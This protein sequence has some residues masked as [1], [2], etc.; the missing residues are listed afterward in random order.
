MKHIVTS[1]KR[2]A[3]YKAVVI[4]FVWCFD[5]VA[6]PLLIVVELLFYWLVF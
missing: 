4:L 2:V 5:V 6:E 3:V 1:K